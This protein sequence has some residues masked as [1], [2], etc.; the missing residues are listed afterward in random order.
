M[1]RDNLEMRRGGTGEKKE[2]QT[3][4]VNKEEQEQNQ[5]QKMTISL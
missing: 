1:G 5:T 3:V 2:R 4:E